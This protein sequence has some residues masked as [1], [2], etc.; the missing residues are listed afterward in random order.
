M[1]TALGDFDFEASMYL[2]QKENILYWIVWLL[3]VVMTTIIFLNFIIA[4]ASASY[5]KVKENLTAM[6]HKEKASLIA[7]AEG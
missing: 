1:R 3:A 6:I 7:E 4:E 2:T 5:E